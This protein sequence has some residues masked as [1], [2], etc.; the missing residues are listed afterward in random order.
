MTTESNRVGSRSY[1]MTRYDQ[2]DD[3]DKNA[4]DP[5]G[6]DPFLQTTIVLLAV[7]AAAVV[8]VVAAAV[9]VLVLVAAAVQFLLFLLLLLQLLSPMCSVRVGIAYCME[10]LRYLY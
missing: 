1:E 10:R 9:A 2:A 3:R 8:V 6:D 5:P 4:N 7:A